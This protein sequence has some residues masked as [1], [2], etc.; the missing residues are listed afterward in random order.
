M[1]NVTNLVYV[2]ESDA[3]AEASVYPLL[4]QVIQNS[5]SLETIYIAYTYDLTQS[6]NQEILNNIY[7]YQLDSI[8][9]FIMENNY[10]DEQ[11]LS[12]TADILGQAPNI[13]KFVS[14]TSTSGS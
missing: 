3:E 6:Q 4:N 9:S 1:K 13:Q 8:V 14:W 2:S 10:Q 5:Q 11:S 7:D 12:T